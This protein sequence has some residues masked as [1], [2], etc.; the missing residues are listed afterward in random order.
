MSE[1]RLRRRDVSRPFRGVQVTSKP[2]TVEEACRAYLVRLRPGQWFSHSTA[3]LLHGLPLPERL[4]VV[5]PLHVSAVRPQM[6]P[7]AAGV[8]GHRLSSPPLTVLVDG[9]PVCV[10]SEAWCQLGAT[11]TLDETII[12]ADEL[13][14]RAPLCEADAVAVLRRRIAATRRNGAAN[15]EDALREARKG[16]RSPGETRVRL[17]L[18]RAGVMATEL[19]APVT[20]SVGRI[21]GHADLVWRAAR[22]VLEYEGDGHRVDRKQFRYD[23]ERYEVFRDAGWEVIR[24]TGDDL[25]GSRRDALVERVKRRL[26]TRAARSSEFGS[27]FEKPSVG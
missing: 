17:L 10:A 11:L 2:S 3:A 6:P 1:G 5:A 4:E 12:V 25:V 26:R 21:L 9:I 20:D 19:N 22:L 13:L 24:V 16:V 27:Q 8:A 18:V 15:L 7:R 23:I 14:E